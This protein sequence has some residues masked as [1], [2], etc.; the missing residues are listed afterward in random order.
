MFPVRIT[1]PIHWHSNMIDYILSIYSTLYLYTYPNIYILNTSQHMLL[2]S[3]AFQQELLRP[4]LG[5]GSDLGRKVG[6][7]L[8]CL[9]DESSIVLTWCSWP[10]GRRRRG[11]RGPSRNQG[12]GSPEVFKRVNFVPARNY[13]RRR[14]ASDR[15]CPEEPHLLPG[16][17]PVVLLTRLLSTL[18]PVVHLP[19]V[20]PWSA[21]QAVLLPRHHSAG[22]ISPTF[23]HTAVQK[24]GHR[25]GLPQED[26]LQEEEEKTKKE[27]WHVRDRRDMVCVQGGGGWGVEGLVRGASPDYNLTF[28]TAWNDRKYN[29]PLYQL[30]IVHTTEVGKYSFTICKNKHTLNG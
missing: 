13:Q 11:W 15:E 30:H 9:D 29:R 24:G 7:Q 4:S 2:Y 28:P 1:F 18:S 21:S 27:Q 3:P 6:L 26:E 5:R 19:V 10:D 23:L 22:C 20:L 14:R 25:D 8:K 12:L 17:L 16:H